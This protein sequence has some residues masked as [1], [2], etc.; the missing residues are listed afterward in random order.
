MAL[1]SGPALR[2]P[3]ELPPYTA[4]LIVDVKDF[5]G[6]KGRDHARVTEA[7][8]GILRQA[9]RRAGLAD[10]WD[11]ARFEFGTG[12]GYVAGFRPA[13]LPFLLNPFLPALQ[14]ELAYRNKVA[15]DTDQRQPIR[16]RVTVHVGPMTSS[17]AKALS[18]GS[19]V[20]RI[21]AHR[22]ID[23]PPVRDL[24]TRSSPTT[25]V[26][27]IVSA[28]VFADAVQPG[29]TGED[30][31]LYVR[32]PVEVK[33]YEGTAYLRVPAPSG[34]LLVNGFH[35]ARPETDTT[36]APPD[37]T[38]KGGQVNRMRDVHGNV[39]QAHT[40]NETNRQGG[41]GDING[42]GNITLTGAQ[43]TVHI[44]DH[45]F[46]GARRRPKDKK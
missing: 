11:E 24:L 38:A 25:C 29:F 13:V 2:V 41:T 15:M 26:A 7:I 40:Y 44:G 14:E 35:T 20:A 43:G 6:I 30:P 1:E 9:F 31:D 32:A 33:S 17:E 3:A 23:A 45:H 34:D 28:R 37:D 46:S 8:P 10:H 5:S 4:I 42:N 36:A 39:V 12:D 21:E 16:M 22:L 19:G 27:A 18:E